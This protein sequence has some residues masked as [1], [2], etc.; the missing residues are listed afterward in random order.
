[1]SA[2]PCSRF[3][4]DDAPAEGAAFDSLLN[5][6]TA[7]FAEVELGTGRFLR[8]NS[9]FCAM[10]GRSAAELLDGR[11][12]SHVVHPADRAADRALWREGA[13]SGRFR[14]AEKRYLHPDGTVVWARLSVAVLVRWADGRPRRC[15]A[16]VQDVTAAHR[17]LE[18]LHAS[19]SLLRLTM[20]VGRIGSFRHDFTT[21]QV[22][23]CAGTRALYGLPQGDEPVP[24]TDWFAAVLAE[25]RHRLREQNQAAIDAR[26]EGLT[27]DYRIHRPDGQLRHFEARL[28]FGYDGRD[29]V[30]HATGAIIDV[31]EQREAEAR[32]AHIAHH[33]ALTGLPNRTLFRFRLEQQV[34]RARRG[35]G[36]AVLCLDL[37]RFKE[38]NDTLGHS[39]GDALLHAVATRLRAELRDVDTVAR[40][41]GDEFAI[42]QSQVSQPGEATRLA[43]RLIEVLTQP[44]ELQGHQVVVGTSL[45]I[46]LAPEDGLE[47]DTL[48]KNGDMALY[49]AKA[50]G[51]G[52]LCFFEPEMDAKMQARRRLE[53]DLR[54]ALV[55]REFELFFQPIVEVRSR[56]VTGL[57]ALLR[58]NHPERGL[59]PPDSFI[60]LTEE[61][62]LIL[63]LGEWVLEEACA[64]AARWAG[65]TTIAVN[66]SPVQFSSRGLVDTVERALRESGLD[67][68]RLELEITETVMLRDTEATL[69]TLHRLKALGVRIAMDDFGTGY[70]S[71]SYLQRFPFDKVKIDRCFTRDL[72]H[73]QQ[74]GAIIRAVAGMCQGLDMRTTAEGVETEEQ[75]RALAQKGCIEAQGYLFSHPRPAAEISAM[76][77]RLS[78]FACAS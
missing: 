49:R 66:L 71:L 53:M 51:R 74:S 50:D 25:D 11:G 30:T 32:L 68:R 78:Q 8:V 13:S 22:Q 28:R 38:V 21:G 76:L 44:F 42:I 70:S 40:L 35:E 18:R 19:E 43:R 64:Q 67:P 17:T 2:T 58:W 52:R 14:E 73:T 20:D 29:H 7:G 46:S 77:A 36:F 3:R 23:C 69:S 62:G 72:G 57:E 48:L 65:D 9:R 12:P 56:R 10:T 31:T 27:L 47:A 75:F 41:G 34:A 63:P 1:M 24:A 45:G 4:P 54:R 39:L 59:V 61:I 16:I 60:P 15:V 26:A 5:S 55:A 37:D 6:D 33:D